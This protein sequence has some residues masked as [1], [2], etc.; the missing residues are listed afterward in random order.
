MPGILNPHQQALI[1]KTNSIKMNFIKRYRISI[2]LKLIIIF[3]VQ[4]FYLTAQNKGIVLD[5]KSN[6]PLSGVNIY[7]FNRKEVTVTNGKGEYHLHNISKMNM[8]DTIFFSYVGYVSGK[9]PLRE[10]K[11]M[12]FVVTLT[13]DDKILKEVTVVTN[14][15]PLQPELRYKKLASLKEGLYSF[16][17]TLIGDKICIIGGDASF[18]EDQTLKALDLYGDDFL[19]HLKSSFN[20]QEF[21]GNLQIYDIPTNSWTNS[22]LK[23]R[24][25]AYH[26]VQY[27]NGKIYVLGGKMLSGD[28]KTEYLDDKIEVYDIKKNTI[29]VDHTNPHKA[30]NFATFVYNDNLI[31]MGGSTRLKIN[32]EKEY[33]NKVH[34]LNLKTG[35]WYELDNMPEAKESKG[36]LIGNTVYLIG[37][38]NAKALNEMETYN[39]TTG[40]W[41][42]EGKLTFEVERPGIAYNGNVI[43][44][45]DDGKIQTY[46]ILTKELNV[47]L[48]DLALKSSELFYKDNSLYIVGGTEYD[49]YSFSPSADLYRVDL[50]EFKRTE[51]YHKP[52][53]GMRKKE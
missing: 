35:Y 15:L 38:F 22:K 20:W 17:S 7:T 46:N 21:S 29:L 16:G 8:T 19:S 1:Q 9:I 26:T 45:F 34:L 18:G 50:S 51:I 48:I 27:Y 52:E 3:I 42:E 30:I 12:N 53:E 11:E 39:I 41:N 6:K 13:E 33:S 4:V 44:V 14:K 5:G 24:K 2:T 47:Y 23:F 32:G 10:L 37:G 25:R 28:G 31:V 49:D 43:Y 40:N 36:V